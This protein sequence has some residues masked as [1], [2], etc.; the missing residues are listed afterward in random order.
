[1]EPIFND[2]VQE[3]KD[4]SDRLTKVLTEQ[5]PSFNRM[6]QRVKKP[7]IEP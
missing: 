5:V 3:L 2:L 6:L 4:E 1:M 7:A